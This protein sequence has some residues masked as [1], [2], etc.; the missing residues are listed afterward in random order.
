MKCENRH[1]YNKASTT[2]SSHVAHKTYHLIGSPT[3]LVR[4]RR[5]NTSDLLEDTYASAAEPVDWLGDVFFTARLPNVESF[6]D[7]LGRSR[8]G[9]LYIELDRVGSDKM[10]DNFLSLLCPAIHDGYR[11]VITATWTSG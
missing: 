4:L 10:F 1:L 7:I 3:C 8:A 11:A 2:V 9:S 6:A 5:G